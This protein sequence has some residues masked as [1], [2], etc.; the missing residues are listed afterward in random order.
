[1][2]AAENSPKISYQ[3]IQAVAA[4]IIVLAVVSGYAA[5]HHVTAATSTIPLHS[6]NSTTSTITVPHLSGSC[7]MLFYAVTNNVT[8]STGFKTYQLPGIT[9]YVLAPG[10]TG[11]LSYT[12]TVKVLPGN[13]RY[14]IS[15]D[16]WMRSDTEYEI[17]GNK[18]N[19][20]GFNS[21]IGVSYAITT[22]NL[23]QNATQYTVTATLSAASN[24]PHAT[25]YYVL[26]PGL[27]LCGAEMPLITVGSSPYNGTFP[28]SP[29]A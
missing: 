13:P 20:I 21:S 6:N 3:Q 2:S 26:G 5:I 25:Y 8:G 9:N 11:T 24:A 19:N 1:M 12:A 29:A 18:I 27:P 10:S 15:Q 28:A 14:N 7:P 4:V 17:I 22:Q 23:T 16:S